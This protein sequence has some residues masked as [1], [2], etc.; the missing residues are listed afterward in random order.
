MNGKLLGTVWFEINEQHGYYLA[1][2]LSSKGQSLVINKQPSLQQVYARYNSKMDSLVND[3]ISLENENDHLKQQIEQ[4]KNQN[5][6]LQSKSSR[7]HGK[8]ISNM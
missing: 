6:K 7:H 8:V 2:H 5:M 3:K 4:L 1:I